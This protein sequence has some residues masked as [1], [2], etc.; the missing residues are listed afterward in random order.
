MDSERTGAWELNSQARELAAGVFEARKDRQ[1]MNSKGTL[2]QRG[3]GFIGIT[4]D[5]RANHSRYIRDLQRQPA[6]YPEELMDPLDTEATGDTP[7]AL[8]DDPSSEMS[9]SE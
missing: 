7:D 3:K 6:E 5:D 9:L 8:N 1:R 2:N 4:K